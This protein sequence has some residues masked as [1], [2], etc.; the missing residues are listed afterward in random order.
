M[1]NNIISSIYSAYLD[2]E[3]KG[4]QALRASDLQTAY[5]SLEEFEKKHHISAKESNDFDTDILSEFTAISEQIGFT[6]GFKLAIQLMTE[7]YCNGRTELERAAE[8]KQD[9]ATQ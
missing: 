6:N 3:F 1:H 7:V 4:I 2:D 9:T 8:V 5:V